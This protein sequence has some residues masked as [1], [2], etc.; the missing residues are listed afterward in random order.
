M[1][2]QSWIVVELCMTGSGAGQARGAFMPHAFLRC[3]WPMAVVPCDWTWTWSLVR[4]HVDVLAAEIEYGMRI[5]EMRSA[6]GHI[7]LVP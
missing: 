3:R 1:V 2:L 5:R 4:Q 6:N 7:G